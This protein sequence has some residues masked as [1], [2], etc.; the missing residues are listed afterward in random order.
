MTDVTD[1]FDNAYNASYTDNWI[2]LKGILQVAAGDMHAL[3]ERIVDHMNL[4][5]RTSIDQKKTRFVVTPV[6]GEW[7]IQRS[8]V[9]KDLFWFANIPKT[10]RATSEQEVVE[11]IDGVL[12]HLSALTHNTAALDKMDTVSDTLQSKYSAMFDKEYSWHLT[13]DLGL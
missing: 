1:L 6:D 9:T 13:K 12:G 11:Y 5:T 4:T 10:C 7:I 3:Q 2:A 8:Q